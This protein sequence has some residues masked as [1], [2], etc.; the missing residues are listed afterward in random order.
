MIVFDGVYPFSFVAFLHGALGKLFPAA[1]P[2]PTMPRACES[3]RCRPAGEGPVIDMRSDTVT[4][5]TEAMKEV[6]HA[7]TAAY[8]SFRRKTATAAETRLVAIAA[9]A[10]EMGAAAIAATAS[11]IKRLQSRG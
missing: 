1:A 10:A 6:R 9:T 4:T 11:Q 7:R 3:M 8:M 2:A 5:P